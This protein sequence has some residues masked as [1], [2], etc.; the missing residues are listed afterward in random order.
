M[1]LHLLWVLSFA[2]GIVLSGIPAAQ[3]RP[4]RVTSGEHDG[5]SRLVLYLRKKD[6]WEF[7]R[8]QGGFEFRSG[9]PDIT[10]DLR[11]A[12]D[13]IPR[14]RIAELQDLGK[15][16]LF[17]KVECACYADVF[18]LD[19]GQVVLDI[20]DGVA[21]VS[22]QQFNRL[23]PPVEPELPRDP[24]AAGRKSDPRTARHG[25]PLLVAAPA[26]QWLTALAQPGAPRAQ[27]K[28]RMSETEPVDAS[29]PSETEA[30]PAMDA[31]DRIA[32]AKIRILQQIGRAASQGL[33]DPDIS[34]ISKAIEMADPVPAEGVQSEPEPA[35]PAQVRELMPEDHVRVKNAIDPDFPRAIAEGPV[36]SQ[37]LSCP[38]DA[39]FDI[40]A[41]G[42][43]PAQGLRI[44]Y[45]RTRLLEEFDKARPDTVAALAKYYLYLTFGS[46]ARKV[47]DQFAPEYDGTDRIRTMADIVDNLWSETGKA[48]AP[49]QECDGN[50]AMWAILAQKSLS[51]E[52]E[53][54]E[55]G[56]YSAFSALP[57]HLRHRFAPA[58]VSR[59]L[60]AGKS[61]L[62]TQLRDAVERGTVR[63]TPETTYLAAQISMEE[64]Q[65]DQA[66]AELEEIVAGRSGNSAQALIDLVTYKLS[67]G[68]IP[69]EQDIELIASFAFEHQGTEIGRDLEQLEV[70]GLAEISRFGAAFSRFDQLL[71][72]GTIAPEA[73]FSTLLRLVRKLT[74]S[75]SDI[76]FVRY[77]RKYALGLQ[78]P[79]AE[80]LAISQRLL[81]LGFTTEARQVLTKTAQ[82]PTKEER[83]LFARI[84]LAEEKPDIAIGYLA[85]LEDDA[86][87]A[88]R[89]QALLVRNDT[90]GAMQIFDQSGNTALAE[91]LA[92]RSGNWQE[93]MR[94]KNS[95]LLEAA[96]L[97][98]VETQFAADESNSDNMLALDSALLQTAVD[99]R[100][101]IEGLLN[102]FSE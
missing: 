3:A 17:L 61:D 91:E 86:S 89:A 67:H 24:D 71:G 34:R 51:D 14:D 44:G 88:L 36:T 23:L 81:D 75:G 29:R 8:T 31:E 6:G 78:L 22:A 30:P 62:A 19:G 10:F 41:W 57:I 84:A 72:S 9:D 16:R 26:K 42:T 92:F 90:A 39:L 25:L 76:E 46:E 52:Y 12:F 97:A 77:A 74:E 101:V 63:A 40:G 43:D 50:T 59:L 49:Y 64:D 98:L 83:R 95:E 102:R 55:S 20:L 54:N 28:P 68:M 1:R 94:F 11:R 65:R 66:L 32:D 35:Q 85:G 79:R 53:L 18:A 15:G 70:L 4:V 37:G 100:R 56:V 82:I 48:W 73:E 27:E 60:S 93:L 45:Y 96:Q 33:L 47:L 99:T 38:D 87:S 7:G 21:P 2:M 69:S 13:L 58:L 5:F 80:R